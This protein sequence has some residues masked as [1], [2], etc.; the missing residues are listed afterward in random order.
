MITVTTLLLL[1]TGAR[2]LQLASCITPRG[3]RYG[4]AANVTVTAGPSDLDSHREFLLLRSQGWGR[5][6]GEVKCLQAAI[7]KADR[8]TS[9]LELENDVEPSKIASPKSD[10]LAES[11]QIEFKRRWVGGDLVIGLSQ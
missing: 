5:E 9:Q 8:Q 2:S 6:V 7:L 11:R 4:Y 10:V 3:L 1:V